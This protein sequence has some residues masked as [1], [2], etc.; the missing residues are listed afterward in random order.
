MNF[1]TKKELSCPCCDSYF[2]KEETL[3][4]LD[5]ARKKAGIAFIISSACRCE[6]HNKEVGGSPLSAHKTGEAVDLIFQNS[7]EAFLILESLIFVGFR[8][9][10]I[11]FKKG[12]IHVDSSKTLPQEVLFHY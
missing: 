10:G 12:F 5:E 11:N 2:F 6:K 1:F 7:N 8:R 3:E 4:M 9:I